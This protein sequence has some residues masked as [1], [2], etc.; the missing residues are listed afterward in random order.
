MDEASVQRA[1]TVFEKMMHEE[2]AAG[3]PTLIRTPNSNTIRLLDYFATL[4]AEDK[5]ALIGSYA[6]M[7]ALRL[8][9]VPTV[10]SDILRLVNDDPNVMRIRTALQSPQF[11][12]GLRYCG[13]RMRKA[14]LS[15]P[16][17]IQ[18]MAKTRAELE[19]IPRDDMPAELVPDPET[20]HLKPAKAP[21]LRKLINAEFKTLFNPDKRKL[22]G[23]ETV[24]EGVLEDAQ[25][26]VRT[27]FGGMGM[28]LRYSVTV[29]PRNSVRVAL[30]AYEDLWM[31]GGGWDY[32]TEEN[33][34]ASIRLLGEI[35]LKLAR[36][37]R[38]VAVAVGPT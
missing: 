32:L 14:M 8:F 1:R 23:G 16:M 11:S 21:E 19:F 35:I 22:A 36:L 29:E 3:F 25:V 26:T 4:S 33:A 10:Q 20:A 27:D 15:D 28:Q 34:A 24:Y 18:M 2:A 7:A 6:H 12:M 37:R 38:D 5:E 31:G 13:L 9:P 17:S 30:L